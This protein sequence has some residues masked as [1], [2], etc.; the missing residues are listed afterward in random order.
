VAVSID[1]QPAQVIYAGAA[2]GMVAGVMQINVQI[3]I[4]TQPGA[5]VPVTL[6]VGKH[7]SA[8]NVSIAVQ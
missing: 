3:P 8:Q 1:G 5:A 4:G 6:A 2:P 7:I